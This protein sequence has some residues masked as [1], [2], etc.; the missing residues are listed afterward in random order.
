M[1][2]HEGGNIREREILIDPFIDDPNLCSIPIIPMCSLIGTKNYDQGVT[3]TIS[4]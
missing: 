3:F 2:F 4:T 1:L